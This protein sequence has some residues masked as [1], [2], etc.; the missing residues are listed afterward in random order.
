MA[1]A[2]PAD[3]VR[4]IKTYTV[5][6]RPN[7]QAP[8]QIHLSAWDVPLLSVHYNQKGLLFAYPPDISL[9]QIIQRLR[10]SLEE[11]L[12]HF[13]PASGR[14]R[15][16]T[17]EGGGVTCHVEVGI[18]GEGAEF[19]H[20]VADGIGIADVVAADGRD[21]PQFLKD[22]FPLD[23]AVNFDGCTNPLLAVQVTELIDGVFIGLTFNHVIIDGTSFWH[24]F[25][26]WAEI[27]RC[28]AAGKE[29]VLSQPPVHDRWFIEGYGEPPIRLPYS[30]PAQFV[31]RF[32]PPPLLSDRMF[33]FSRESLVNLKERANQECGKGTISTFQA[34]SALMWRCIT[35]ARRLTFEQKTSW[36]MSI[37]NR[38]R[39]QPPLSPNYFGNSFSTVSTTTTAGELLDNNLGWAAWLVHQIISN[40]TDSAIRNIVHKY[41]ENSYV[42]NI[43]TIDIIHSVMMGS[44][45]RFD[46]YGCN[47]GWGKALAVRSG[48]SNKFDGKLMAFPGWNGDGSIDLEVCLL[49]EYMAVLEKDEEFLAVVSAPIEFGVL[50]GTSGKKV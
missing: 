40:H 42:V 39:L 48:S 43:R 14:L 23:L 18:E 20:A 41:M 16:L 11:A 8:R 25:N 13:Y 1:S 17:C 35:R 3:A 7:P 50:L 34:L 28:Q 47:F 37:Q 19:V 24:F 44:S 31:V 9:E 27:A 30:S 36:L 26:A 15:V 5:T 29:V 38:T 6:P 22:F 49:P 10:S 45:P 4:T 46:V 12:F 21:L 2:S 33:H 32:S